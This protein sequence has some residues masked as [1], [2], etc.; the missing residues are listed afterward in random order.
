M[1]TPSQRFYRAAAKSPREVAKGVDRGA[2][3]VAGAL[4]RRPGLQR[5]LRREAKAVL[6]CHDRE[7]VDLDEAALR[8]RLVEVHRRLRRG[9][10]GQDP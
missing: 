9:C 5:R 4:R 2:D 8:A 3:W 10:G 7:I 1:I 6:R